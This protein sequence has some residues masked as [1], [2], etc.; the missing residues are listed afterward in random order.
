MSDKSSENSAMDIGW[1]VNENKRL[2]GEI[3]R[4]LSSETGQI[5]KMANEIHSTA[6]AHGWWEGNRSFGDLIALM[7]SELSEALEAYREGRHDAAIAVEFADVIIRV[8]DA[9]VGLGY[10]IEAIVLEK[11]KY[12][13]T[14]PYRHGGKKL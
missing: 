9:S 8:L 5:T 1:Y 12:N 11:M 14:R 3:A 2:Q 4:L 13:K 7:H 6:K 10:D